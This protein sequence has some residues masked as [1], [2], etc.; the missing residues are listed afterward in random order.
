[1]ADSVKAEEPRRPYQ[2]PAFERED[3]FETMALACNKL[4]GGCEVGPGP[5]KGNK[6]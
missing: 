1:M 5:G 3:V 4:G 6:S 2:K